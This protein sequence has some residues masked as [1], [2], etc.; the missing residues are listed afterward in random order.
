MEVILLTD[1]PHVGRLGE[2][3]RVASGFARNYLFPRRL[4]T[5][6]TPEAKRLVNRQLGKKRA[7][8]EA[9]RDEVL[10][11]IE[12]LKGLEIQLSCASGE[13]GRLFGSVTAR[14]IAEQLAAKGFAVDKRNIIINKPIRSLGSH[15]VTIRLHPESQ[16]DISIVVVPQGT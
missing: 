9:Q 16:T 1:V 4:A 6:S 10:S 13:G 14:Q 8:L 5:L 12:R 2:M 3:K 11:F 15:P 7:L